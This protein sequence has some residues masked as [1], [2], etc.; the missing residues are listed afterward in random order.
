MLSF[1]GIRTLDELLLLH[2]RT[3][4]WWQHAILSSYEVSFWPKAASPI[5]AFSR[6]SQFKSWT[7]HIGQSLSPWTLTAPG[8]KPQPDKE[9]SRTKP[10]LPWN[11]SVSSDGHYVKWFCR[12]GSDIIIFYSTRFLSAV[13][14][15]TSLLAHVFALWITEKIEP[16]RS[17]CVFQWS[18]IYNLASTLNHL[19]PSCFSRGRPSYQRPIPPVCSE[20]H[21]S[22][23]P[24]GLYMPLTSS[25][26]LF[27]F[28]QPLL[29]YRSIL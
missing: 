8:P 2:S 26:P 4:E 15:Y 14:C 5:T 29:G 28:H 13:L 17:S 25:F 10:H 6:T 20:P 1:Y 27:S 11:L 19:R 7:S 24:Q 3:S 23:P 22:L 18:Q 16:E 9:P 21:P 12:S